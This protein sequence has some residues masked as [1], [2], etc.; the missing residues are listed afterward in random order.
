MEFANEIFLYWIYILVLI[1]DHYTQALCE[2]LA[3]PRNRAQGVHRL[4]EDR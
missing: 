2:A 3:Q 1:D 4:L